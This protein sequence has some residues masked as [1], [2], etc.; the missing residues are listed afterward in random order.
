MYK[1]CNGIAATY[2]HEGMA[3]SSIFKTVEQL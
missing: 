3:P 2:L 1:E